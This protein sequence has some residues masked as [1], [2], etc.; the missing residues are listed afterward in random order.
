VSKVFVVEDFFPNNLH[1]EIV[2]KMLTCSYG[3]PAKDQREHYDGAYWHF[4]KLSK[5]CAVQ[6]KIKE[7]IKKHFLYD[8]KTFTTTDYTMVGATD[9]PR[10][11]VDLELGCTHQ[12]LIYMHGPESVNNGTGFYKD[13]QLNIHVGFKPNRAIFFSSDVFHTSLQWSGNGSFRYSIANFFT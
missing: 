7:F 5:G 11:H 9:K 2:Q 6:I 10:P 1:D 8:V 13:G 12:C 4:H 3:P